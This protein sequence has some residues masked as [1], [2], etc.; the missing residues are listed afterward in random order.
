MRVV[1]TFKGHAPR[2]LQRILKRG[3]PRPC[4]NVNLILISNDSAFHS[5]FHWYEISF[6]RLQC[7]ADYTQRET[8]CLKAKKL[9]YMC[10]CKKS[11]NRNKKNQVFPMA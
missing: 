3:S 4:H 6:R 8:R 9:K 2:S 10:V 1:T 7:N 5:I 11:T